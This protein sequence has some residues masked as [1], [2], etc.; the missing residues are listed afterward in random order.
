MSIHS[1]RLL[2]QPGLPTTPAPTQLFRWQAE[3]AV[4]LSHMPCQEPFLPSHPSSSRASWIFLKHPLYW[5]VFSNKYGICIICH[6][7]QVLSYWLPVAF[8][9]NFDSDTQG[10]PQNPNQSP[11]FPSSSLRSHVLQSSYSLFYD[12][13]L[14][15]LAWHLPPL[16][17]TKS[18]SLWQSS[19]HTVTYNNFS[20]LW[21]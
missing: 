15:I 11:L 4:I 17:S 10:P 8:R 9:I 3:A 21:I 14:D 16:L 13:I 20:W 12:Q 18:L 2:C 19:L 6:S 5:K 1:I 7:W